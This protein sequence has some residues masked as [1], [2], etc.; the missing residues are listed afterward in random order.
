MNTETSRLG[1]EY[2]WTQNINTTHFDIPDNACVDLTCSVYNIKYKCINLGP[3]PLSSVQKFRSK[4][5]PLWDFHTILEGGGG[6]GSV[7]SLLGESRIC[8]YLKQSFKKPA[9]MHT[10]YE[11]SFLFLFNIFTKIFFGLC[12]CIFHMSNLYFLLFNFDIFMVSPSVCV[13]VIFDLWWWNPNTSASD[14][15]HE[16]KVCKSVCKDTYVY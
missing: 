6:G 7:G 3:P 14:M 4:G 11:K 8:Q 16:T 10:S 9:F 13:Q 1:L 2:Y 12:C 15:W 5:P